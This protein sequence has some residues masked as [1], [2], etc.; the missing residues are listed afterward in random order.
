MNAAQ[1]HQGR[2]AAERTRVVLLDLDGTLVD[3]AP[4]MV[5]AL[6]QLRR[7]AGHDSL[8]LE[9]VRPLVSH[10]ARALVQMGFPQASGAEFE[11][12]RGRFLDIYRSRLARET[13]VYDGLGE[14]LTRLE[15]A[16]IV[17][18]IVTNKPGWLT[19][20]LLEHLA[21]HQRAAVVVSGDTLQQRKPHPAPL[22]H[23]AEKLRASPADCIYVGDAERDVLAAQAAGMRAYVALFGYIPANERPR[24]WPASGWL[25]SPALMARWLETLRP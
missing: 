10:G 23:A 15:S 6:N 8:P 1:V 4:D 18:G 3:T 22:L 19:Q 9:E 21:L 7:E 25:E 12:L 14:A 11:A 2:A 5:G 24:D 17:W 20:P 16:G 13:K